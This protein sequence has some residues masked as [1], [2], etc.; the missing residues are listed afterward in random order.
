MDGVGGFKLSLYSQCDTVAHSELGSMNVIKVVLPDVP[1]H[2]PAR[3]SCIKEHRAA[4]SRFQLLGRTFTFFG[5]KTDH[6]MANTRAFL[7]AEKEPGPNPRWRSADEARQLL[8]DF[9]SL[10]DVSK[11]GRRLEHAFSSTHRA[12]ADH[13]FIDQGMLQ[14]DDQRQLGQLLDEL[15][16]RPPVPEGEAHVFLFDDIH[17]TGFDAKGKRALMT[18]GNG[19]ISS[20]LSSTFPRVSS[21]L[22]REDSEGAPLATQMRLWLKGSLDKGVL[23]TDPQLPP[24]YLLIRKSNRKIHGTEGCAARKQGISRLEV[25]SRS[26]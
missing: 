11:E 24:G 16:A 19:L 1:T 18:D 4:L 5:M 3:E 22:C 26:H 8:A 12:L 6:N 15:R 21:G 13:T 17:G 7:I 20:N 23:T 9:G 14:L 2:G 25:S 10:K